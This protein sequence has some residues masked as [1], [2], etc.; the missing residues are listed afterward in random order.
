VDSDT[1]G[2]CHDLDPAKAGTLSA[3]SAPYVVP[4]P[5][6]MYGPQDTGRLE[7]ILSRLKGR[8]K[9][10]RREAFLEVAGPFPLAGRASWS[11]DWH[12]FR[13][14]PEPHLHKGLDLLAA[15]GTPVV[16]VADGQVTQVVNIADSSGLG[17]EMEDGNNIQYFYAHLSRFAPGL[18]LG[19]RVRRGD[20]LGYVGTTGN[21]QGGVPHL[22]FEI[23]P[24]GV[25]MPPKPLVDRWLL[26]AEK[27]ARI[28]VTKGQ[29]ALAEHKAQEPTFLP[30][31]LVEFAGE[32]AAAAVPATDTETS[33]TSF[34]APVAV[35]SSL[36]VTGVALGLIRRRRWRGPPDGSEGEP[37][38]PDGAAPP[39]PPGSS[40]AS[41]ALGPTAASLIGLL[42]SLVLIALWPATRR[43]RP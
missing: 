34:A 18:R 12:N 30:Q 28:L 21:A 6:G 17:V 5:P 35:G 8:P 42:V 40:T 16:A 33:S 22:H 1:A 15:A 26:V 32:A 13:P 43:G 39:A 20:V 31:G 3:P 10:S 23:Q 24:G 38:D 36:V 2:D 37:N 25:A 7:R 27:R 19:Q 29:R 9:L 4:E 14:C 11:D 41:S